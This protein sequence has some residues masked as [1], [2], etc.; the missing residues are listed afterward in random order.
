MPNLNYDLM[1]LENVT[2]DNDTRNDLAKYALNLL[3]EFQY[4]EIMR[5]MSAVQE[6]NKFYNWYQGITEI[7]M[8]GISNWAMSSSVLDYTNYDIET[9]ASSGLIRSRNYGQFLNITGVDL[10]LRLLLDIKVPEVIKE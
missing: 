6:K 2:L 5:N 4:K 10:N 9:Y 7:E 8:V 3:N 1:K